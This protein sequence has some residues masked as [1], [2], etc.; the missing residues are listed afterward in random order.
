[1]LL[2]LIVLLLVLLLLLARLSVLLLLLILLLLILLLLVLLLLA[3]LLL[4]RAGRL[5]MLLAATVPALTSH[6]LVV[7]LMLSQNLLPHLL[8]ALVDVRVKLIAVLLVGELL[9]IIDWN[10]DLLSAY[11][12]LLRVVEL[13]YVRVL[14]CLLGRQALVR[15]EL[16]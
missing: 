12:L 3:V 16:K 9:I 13:G 4:L 6:L 5:G 10:E 11:W 1:M 7:C 2:L 8:L 15:V 14:Q